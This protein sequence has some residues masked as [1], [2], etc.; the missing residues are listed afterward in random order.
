MRTKTERKNLHNGNMKSTLSNKKY[1]FSFILAFWRAISRGLFINLKPKIEVK[2]V[3][4]KLIKNE[5]PIRKQ[6]IGIQN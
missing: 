1:L 3:E 2:M 5:D 6:V 4:W